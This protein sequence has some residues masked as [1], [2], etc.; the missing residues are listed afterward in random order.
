MRSGG[1]RVQRAGTVTVDDDHLTGL[2]LADERGA[3]DVERGRLAG[4]HPAGVEPSQAQRPEAVRV[5]D[6]VQPLAVEQHQGEGAF[7]SGQ[8]RRQGVGEV[9]ALVGQV[10]GQQ[11]GDEVAVGADD[12]GQHP[13]LVGQRLGVGEVAVVA[14]RELLGGAVPVH[15][16]GV[17]PRAR[18]RGAVAGVADGKVARERHEG[19]VVEDVGHQAHVLHHGEGVAVGHR[20]AGRL[21]AAVLQGVETQVGEVGDP[22]A[23]GEHPEDATGLPG[24]AVAHGGQ[25]GTATTPFRPT[26]TS[27]VGRLRGVRA[28]RSRPSRQCHLALGDFAASERAEVAHRFG[29]GA[30]RRGAPSAAWPSRWRRRRPRTPCCPAWCRPARSTARSCRW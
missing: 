16:L 9:A 10:P 30:S 5:A 24:V 11:L 12:A 13:G 14:E 8:H 3:D 19:A 26:P 25:S 17:A 15:R 20:H 4:Q 7:G 2:E 22:L 21:L 29:G 1:E 23:G 18:A 28:R 6:A 27:S